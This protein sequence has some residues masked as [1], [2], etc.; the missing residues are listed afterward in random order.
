MKDADT[1]YDK[2]MQELLDNSADRV[3]KI[4][5]YI[6]GRS[7]IYKYKTTDNKQFNSWHMATR[8]Q[9]ELDRGTYESNE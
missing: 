3:E 8:H 7:F 5:V 1:L 9:Y 4:T 6:C 2:K